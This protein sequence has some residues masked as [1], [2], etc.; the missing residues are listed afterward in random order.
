M[1]LFLIFSVWLVSLEYCMFYKCLNKNEFVLLIKTKQNK[2][3]KKKKNEFVLFRYPMIL[4]REP[5][6][7]PFFLFLMWSPIP[8][9]CLVL[10]ML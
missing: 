8:F 7:F 2:K 3:R 4:M 5:E 1:L 10:L 9:S 6:Y